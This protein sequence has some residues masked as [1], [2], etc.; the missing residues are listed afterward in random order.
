MSEYENEAGGLYE[1]RWTKAELLERI[2]FPGYWP[3]GLPRLVMRWLREVYDP[4]DMPTLQLANTPDGNIS[5]LGWRSEENPDGPGLV[6]AVRGYALTDEEQRISRLW[7]TV[8]WCPRCWKDGYVLYD[9]DE[10]VRAEARDAGFHPPALSRTSREEG[11]APIYV[12]SACGQDEAFEEWGGRLTPPEGW[13]VTGPGYGL[14]I[15][16]TG[17][18]VGTPPTGPYGTNE[19]DIWGAEGSAIQDRL[20][21]GQVLIHEIIDGEEKVYVTEDP[22]LIERAA[23]GTIKYLA[24]KA[25]EN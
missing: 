18:Y 9:A 17:H 25:E 23:A 6:E 20:P 5:L 1:E 3:P 16:T 21:E 11:D 24:Q 22:E 19:G 4:R 2:T 13:P 12:C 14:G 7:P 15:D 10:T 8:Q